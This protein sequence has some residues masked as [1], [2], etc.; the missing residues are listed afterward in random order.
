MSN[1]Y[2]YVAKRARKNRAFGHLAIAGDGG[3]GKKP[4][5]VGGGGNESPDNDNSNEE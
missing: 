2:I 4:A 5:G 1:E 3:A